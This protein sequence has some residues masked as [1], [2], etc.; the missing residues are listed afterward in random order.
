MYVE[1]VLYLVAT[2]T[3]SC[4][5]RCETLFLAQASARTQGETQPKTNI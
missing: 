3:M 4:V 5:G 2:V 1:Y